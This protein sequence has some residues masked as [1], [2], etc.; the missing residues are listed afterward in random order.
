MFKI[1][2]TREELIVPECVLLDDKHYESS[3]KMQMK[4]AI[5]SI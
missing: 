3:L 4:V 2:Y 5:G 1:D